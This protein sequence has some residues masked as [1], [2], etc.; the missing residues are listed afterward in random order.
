MIAEIEPID[1]LTDIWRLPPLCPDLPA[2][3]ILDQGDGGDYLRLDLEAGE[4]SLGL[5][6]I[7]SGRDYDLLV[8]DEEGR[9]L[10]SSQ[11]PGNLPE[12]LTVRLPAG[13]YAVRVY[14]SIGRSPMPYEL[15]WK[16]APARLASCTV[17]EQS[18]SGSLS[19]ITWTV[20]VAVGL[21]GE[22]ESV[23]R[24]SRLPTEPTKATPAGQY[25]FPEVK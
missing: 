3:G 23:P 15:R 18:G 21:A 16:L 8:Y 14:P 19:P 12:A 6:D 25:R 5:S 13:T 20:M 22:S 1:R 9:S 7:P 10:G 4:L 24:G 11:Q 2:I 17:K